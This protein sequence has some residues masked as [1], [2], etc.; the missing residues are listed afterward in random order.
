[1]TSPIRTEVDDFGQPTPSGITAGIVHT[2]RERSRAFAVRH[3]TYC[4]RGLMACR[5][6]STD[7]HDVWDGDRLTTIYVVRDGNR[8]VG[9]ARS[10]QWNSPFGL[11]AKKFT[12]LPD[13]IDETLLIEAS[14]V[15]LDPRYKPSPEVR[16]EALLK[17]LGAVIQHRWDLGHYRWVQT[18]RRGMALL[19]CTIG[20][21]FEP[22]VQSI[23]ITD[24]DADGVPLTDEQ[25]YLGFIDLRNVAAL[26]YVDYPEVYRHFFGT[27]EPLV[28]FNAD[29]LDS[30]RKQVASNISI[31]RG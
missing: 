5:L 29:Q 28:A 9:S 25:L 20:V 3:A 21:P 27:T 14:R 30:L 24:H 6:H 1:M 19:L 26:T 17:L 23:Q 16:K 10:I 18:M 11:Q 12:S 8:I 7:P 2:L 4:G 13:G 15:A 31:L 22:P